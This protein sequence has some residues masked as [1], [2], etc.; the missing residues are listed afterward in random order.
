MG[1]VALDGVREVDAAVAMPELAGAD[2]GRGDAARDRGRASFAATLEVAQ[3]AAAIPYGYTLCVWSGSAVLVD[4]GRRPGVAGILGYT[5][6]AVGAFVLLTRSAVRCTGAPARLGGAV[7][8]IPILAV[9]GGVAL[10]TRVL[11]DPWVWAVSGAAVTGTYF[12]AVAAQA[13]VLARLGA[14]MRNRRAA[15][16]RHRTAGVDCGPG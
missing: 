7:R 6:G 11:G 14:A 8:V 5:L 3:R 16:D 2:M 4:A 1:D 9:V 12:L 15:S 10:I 13:W